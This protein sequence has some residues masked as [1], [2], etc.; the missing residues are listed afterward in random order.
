MWVIE[1]PCPYCEKGHEIPEDCIYGGEFTAPCGN[2]VEVD[3]D[4]TYHEESME[5]YEWRHL[6][7]SIVVE[8]EE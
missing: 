3:Y 2:V 1:L 6:N 4:E 5:V 7:K 8:N